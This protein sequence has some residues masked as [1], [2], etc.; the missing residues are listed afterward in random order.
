MNCPECKKQNTKVV[1]SRRMDNIKAVYRRRICKDCGHRFTTLE[2]VV[3]TKKK[4][5]VLSY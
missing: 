5:C 1:D 3:F 4:R 2:R